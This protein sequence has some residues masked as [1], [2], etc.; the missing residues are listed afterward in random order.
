MKKIACPKPEHGF[1][2]TVLALQHRSV[3]RLYPGYRYPKGTLIDQAVAL[4]SSIEIP[5]AK[6]RHIF[7][8]KDACG[9]FRS[10]GS[11]ETPNQ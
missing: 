1:Q 10:A 6:L 8:L 7:L 3:E 9:K 5:I 4:K 2:C 11:S